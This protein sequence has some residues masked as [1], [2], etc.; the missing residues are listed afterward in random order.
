MANVIHL[1]DGSIHTIFDEWDILELVDEQMGCEVCEAVRNLLLEKDY[2]NSYIDDLESDL[3][4][5]KAHHREVMEQLRT[6]SETIAGLIR[7]KEIDRRAL[8]NAAGIIGSVTW[9]EINVR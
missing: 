7:E 5:T 2:E 9:R 8:S 6:Q 3:E 4:G 1:V